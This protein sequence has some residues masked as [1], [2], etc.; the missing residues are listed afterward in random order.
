MPSRARVPASLPRAARSLVAPLALGAF[1]C[2][3]KPPVVTAPMVVDLPAP[4]DEPPRPP[5][6]ARPEG[7]GA[8]A[9]RAGGEATALESW[10]PR[11]G[12]SLCSSFDYHPEGGLQ[13]VW[14]HRPQ[15]VTLKA[16]ADV[17]S[18][19]V[20][21]SGPHSE[22]ELE[23]KSRD[24]FGHYNPA[25][26]RYLADHAVSERGSMAQ[27]ATQGSYDRHLK[28]LATIFWQTYRKIQAEP[29]CFERERSAYAAAIRRKTPNYYE[30]WFYFMNPAF[31]NKGQP[32]ESFLMSHG[33]DGG[34]D[35]NVTKSVVGFWLRRS[36]DGTFDAFAAALKKGLDAY[37]PALLSGAMAPAVR[38]PQTPIW[39]R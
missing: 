30:R 10:L 36:M 34:V 18:V 39:G 7:E 11:W 17:A 14:C 37:D 16:L 26:V 13:S 28:P 22:T 33:F 12:A 21:L 27:R 35:G 31:C 6:A 1:A 4:A 2:A 32:V 15:T 38:A 5:A 25:F 24:T 20:F 19:P 8:G 29:A 23:L 9:D 3:A